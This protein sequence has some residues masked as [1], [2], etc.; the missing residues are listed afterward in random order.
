MLF[1]IIFIKAYFANYTWVML[2]EACL[3]GMLLWT[4]GASRFSLEISLAFISKDKSYQPTTDHRTE[5]WFLWV[6]WAGSRG[7]LLQNLMA[8]RKELPVVSLVEQ[9][10][11]GAPIVHSG[12]LGSLQIGCCQS[13]LRRLWTIRA[14]LVIW[15][16]SLRLCR[17]TWM[18]AMCLVFGVSHLS[19]FIHVDSTGSCLHF[20][21]E[22]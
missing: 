2:E 17:L 11:K 15:S 18:M 5:E 9:S 8:H 3:W 22:P 12:Y 19:S 14:F 20:C 1:H 21:Y 16:F 10:R 7:P 4:R 13:A 6:A